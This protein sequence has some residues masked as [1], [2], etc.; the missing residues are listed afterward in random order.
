MPNEAV[1]TLASQPTLS[2]HQYETKGLQTYNVGKTI[3][4]WCRSNFQ[5]PKIQYFCTTTIMNN[6]AHRIVLSLSALVIVVKAYPG[7]VI[8]GCAVTPKEWEGE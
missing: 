2:K 1:H 6:I 8:Y 3:S 7:E 4:Y 5:V